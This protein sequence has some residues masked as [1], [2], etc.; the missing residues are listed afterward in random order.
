MWEGQQDLIVGR[1][2]TVAYVDFFLLLLTSRCPV[3]GQKAFILEINIAALQ[4]TYP[5]I[6]P[7]PVSA[8]DKKCSWVVLVVSRVGKDNRFYQE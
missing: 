6:H 3:V 5:E 1:S 2:W 7:D 4:D 8:C